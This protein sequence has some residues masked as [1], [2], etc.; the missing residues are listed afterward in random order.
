VGAQST[1]DRFTYLPEIG[2]SIALA[3]SAADV[4]RRR[5]GCRLAG[6]VAAALALAVL[7]AL[8][9][10][11]TSFWRSGETLWNHA[12][13]VSSTNEKA[14]DLLGLSLADAGRYDEAIAHYRQALEIDPEFSGAHINFGLALCSLRKTDEAIAHF[15]RALA[16]EPDNGRAHHDL[17]VALADQGRL[18]EAAIHA[19]RAL[20]IKPD[21]VEAENHLGAIRARQGK[22][23]EAIAHFERALRIQPDSAAA[24]D[25]LGKVLVGL[26]RSDGA[27]AHFRQALEIRPGD[28]EAHYQLALALAD[29]GQ[30]EE[31][32]DHYRQDLAVRPG[33]AEAH[34]NLAWLLAT[35]PAAGVRDGAEA[36]A[37]A[38]RARQLLGELP[39]VLDTLA[40]AQAEAARFPEALATARQALDRAVGQK[41]KALAEALRRRIALYAAGRPYRQSPAPIAPR[42]ADGR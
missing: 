25:N 19:R 3:W 15:R 6:S 38:A 42:G 31:A 1:A 14:H 23:D 41:E 39:G 29:R 4:C 16:I 18:A 17:A 22:P 32:A 7:T 13:A 10:R 35:C 24:H 36:V 5:P 8:A 20:A 28:A 11:Q 34:N 40:A 21:M 33:H 26:G 2:L 37:H 27:L 12:L 30:F 9:W